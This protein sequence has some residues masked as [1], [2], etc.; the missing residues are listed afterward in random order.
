M[1][2]VYLITINETCE[3]FHEAYYSETNEEAERYLIGRGF[4]KDNLGD[5]AK[6]GNGEIMAEICKISCID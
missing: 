3:W 5:W 2:E 4:V 1:N 6:K